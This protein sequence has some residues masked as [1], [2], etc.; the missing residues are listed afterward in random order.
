MD[1]V[2]DTTNF[3][4]AYPQGLMV[5]NPVYGTQG[6]GWN[7]LGGTLSAND[8][9]DFSLKLI[10]QIKADYLIDSSRIHVTGWSM[11]AAMAYEMA[12]VHSNLIASIA[13]VSN[14]MDD[15]SLATCTPRKMSFLQ[16]HGTADPIIPF[17]GISAGGV[18]FSAAP[19][20][21]AFFAALSS[22]SDSTVTEIEN[23]NTTD[24]STVTLIEYA[25]CN[26]EMEVL[27][28][29]INGGGHSWPGGGSVPSFLGAVNQDIDASSEILSFFKRNPPV[30]S[31]TAIAKS[32]DH[33]PHKTFRLYQN[34]PNPF[35]SSTKI[36][37]DLPASAYVRLTIYNMLGRENKTMVS[38]FQQAGSYHFDFDASNLSNG[39]YF[40]QLKVDN[41][42][43]ETK[44]ML[45][46]K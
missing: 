11:G 38:E 28:Y 25:A 3:F 33:Q 43:S 5:N 44:K 14:Q 20:T 1:Q 15:G 12:C 16:M 29:R 8:D 41:R 24:E 34:Y 42:Y 30:E 31:P 17:N 37:Y 32:Q 10:N 18:V 46:I 4:I 27:F 21:A 9:V 26:D 13:A 23:S 6:V 36:E 2:A 19:K 40:Y 45:Y 7:I 35:N 39:V 22:C